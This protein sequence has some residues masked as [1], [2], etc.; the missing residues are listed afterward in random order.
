MILFGDIFCSTLMNVKVLF[1]FSVIA[2][3]CGIPC[4]SGNIL[5]FH[6]GD[7]LG[8]LLRAGAGSG[9]AFIH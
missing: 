6:S 5:H 4:L 1:P 8:M 2:L 7:Q 9:V 3:L